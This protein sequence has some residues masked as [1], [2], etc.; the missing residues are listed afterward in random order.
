MTFL[1]GPRRI[2]ILVITL[3]YII[4]EIYFNLHLFNSLADGATEEKIHSLEVLGRFI[5][6]CG[7]FTLLLKLGIKSSKN[8]GDF[9][10]SQELFEFSFGLLAWFGLCYLV[11]WAFQSGL[12]YSYVKT[13]TDEDIRRA[14]LISVAQTVVSPIYIPPEVISLKNLKEEKKWLFKDENIIKKNNSD[15][16]NYSNMLNIFEQATKERINSCKKDKISDLNINNDIDK[17][18]FSTKSFSSFDENKLNNAITTHYKCMLKNP[19]YFRMLGFMTRSESDKVEDEIRK[20]F[21]KIREMQEKYLKYRKYANTQKKIDRLNSAWNDNFYFYKKNG[22][23]IEPTTSYN[24]T[25]RRVSAYVWDQVDKNQHIKSIRNNG[26]GSDDALKIERDLAIKNLPDSM[27]PMYTKISYYMD[28]KRQ[29]EFQIKDEKSSKI[30]KALVMPMVALSFSVVF[31][32]LNLLS[33]LST[34]FYLNNPALNTIKNII[35]FSG[36]CALILFYCVNFSEKMEGFGLI[37]KVIYIGQYYIL[38]ILDPN[39]MLNIIKSFI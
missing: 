16:E 21:D 23:N 5:T 20:N 31:L 1:N 35:L 38:K 37:A 10:D 34:L 18:F 22:L 14:A 19:D 6:A 24:Q 30:Y 3:I 4:I 25:A 39:Q 26:I 9:H 7:I 17:V 27:T 32:Y 29:S 15:R 13:A 2:A 28:N 11:S 12:T 8:T 33:F 36:F